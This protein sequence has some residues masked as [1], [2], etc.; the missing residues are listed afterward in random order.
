MMYTRPLLFILL[1]YLLCPDRITAQYHF[2]VTPALEEIYQSVW[3][4]SWEKAREAANAMKQEDPEN[5]LVY[6]VENYIDFVRIYLT[7]DMNDFESFRTD[8]THRIAEIQKGSMSSPYYFYSQ[9]EIYIQW[10]LVRSKNGE[11]IRA[12]WDIN[13]AYKLLKKCKEKH[14]DFHFT[15]KSLSVIHTLIGS[16]KGLKKTIIKIL[17]SLDGSVDQGISEIENLYSWNDHNP[18]LWSD[19]IIT[20]RSLMQGHIQK[21]WNDSFETINKLSQNRRTTPLGRYL[22]ASTAYHAGHNDITI[23][24]LALDEPHDH[25]FYYLDL[26]AGTALLN[27]GD[28]SANRF[29]QQYLDHHHGQS[30]LKSASQKMAWYELVIEGNQEEYVRWMNKC[31]LL[32]AT[33]TV[34]DQEAQLSAEQ[35]IIPNRHLLLSRL[36]F[37]GGYYDKAWKEVQKYNP[38]QK[39]KVEILEYTYR[40]ARILQKRGNERE[41]LALLGQTINLGKEEKVYYACNAALQMAYIFF[42]NRDFKNA[43]RYIEITLD[44]HPNE[45][46]ENL[47]NEAKV[48]KER[49]YSAD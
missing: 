9:A 44:I 11:V 25:S 29:I 34:E 16:V 48:L 28:S 43:A 12:G 47:H 2:T 23:D 36:L 33:I 3:D 8:V 41:A 35:N 20:V 15:D 1:I 5:L 31:K 49:L 6:H 18:S 14:P 38:E 39:E 42:N 37:D 24:L 19:E 32:G 45:R 46:K 13:R 17:T 30:F 40:K 4:M 27:K 7:D 21:N 10:S 22:L 26:L